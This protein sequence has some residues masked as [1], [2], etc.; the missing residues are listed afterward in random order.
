MAC[1][2]RPMTHSL[3]P[4]PCVPFLVAL[5]PV[6][7]EF[8]CSAAARQA[9]VREVLRSVD[10]SPKRGRMHFYR[11]SRIPLHPKGQLA[12]EAPRYRSARPRRATGMKVE[13]VWL[14]GGGRVGRGCTAWPA[15]RRSTWRR[16]ASTLPAVGDAMR[17]SL[18]GGGSSSGRDAVVGVGGATCVAVAWCADLGLLVARS[19]GGGSSRLHA[20]GGA[21]GSR[22]A[23][24]RWDAGVVGVCAAIG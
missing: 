22:S 20:L 9:A 5:W 4:L 12:A 13:G 6:A 23:S 18:D 1:G 17:L 14:V 15:Y 16:C 21:D 10:V 8:F 7:R 19:V 11:P 3:C 24:W 2:M